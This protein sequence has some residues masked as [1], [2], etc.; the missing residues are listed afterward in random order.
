VCV[1]NERTKLQYPS[2]IIREAIISS[3]AN[4]DINKDRHA[5]ILYHK[6]GHKQSEMGL[7][8]LVWYA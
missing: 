3:V 1:C 7:D 2:W 8:A 5:F 4:G 6:M